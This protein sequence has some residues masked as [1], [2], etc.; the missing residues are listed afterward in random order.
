MQLYIN[1]IGDRRLLRFLRGQQHDIEK[2]TK[3]YKIFME[4]RKSRN[5]DKIRNEI[6]YGGLNCPTKFPKGQL[7]LKL[8]PQIIIL[9][10]TYDI[11]GQ[12]LVV[13]QFD[14]RPG[15]VL[16]HIT[17]EDYIH[18]LL[19]ALE[20]RALILEQLSEHA[21]RDLLAKYNNQPPLVPQ[22]HGEPTDLGYGI[23]KRCCFIRDLKV[24]FVV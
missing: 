21:E 14:F 12:P 7:I 18:F 23:I 20:Y 22:F 3:K 9:P 16:Q 5:L 17:E 4:F 10:F 6:V 1:C 11:L 8:V 15:E 19:Y 13:E 24:N 2:A